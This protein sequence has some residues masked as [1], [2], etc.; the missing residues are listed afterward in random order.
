MTHQ[1]VELAEFTEVRMA[2]SP[3]DLR[4]ILRARD[5]LLDGED[6]ILLDPAVRALSPEAQLEHLRTNRRVGLFVTGFASGMPLLFFGAGAIVLLLDMLGG[7][8]PVTWW[9]VGIAVALAAFV[10]WH[11]PVLVR[12][13]REFGRPL[14]AWSELV[15]EMGK[16]S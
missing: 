5:C 7:H 10:A 9:S 13:M 3:P 8:H 14:P 6:Q 4:S 11:V 1:R 2:T 15:E 16:R 12:R